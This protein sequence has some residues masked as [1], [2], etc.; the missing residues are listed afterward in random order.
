MQAIEALRIA[1]PYELGVPRSSMHGSFGA[2]APVYVRGEAYLALHRGADA[3]AEFRKVLAHPGVIGSD[4]VGALARLQ[5]ARAYA[6]QGEEG[7]A[8]DAYRALE[9]LWQGA[10]SVLPAVR[11]ATAESAK[12]RG[13]AT[14]AALHHPM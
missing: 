11:Q 1:A 5:L 14:G 2:L 3:A 13:S 10:D 12:L 9:A 4:P 6:M 8:M 7:K